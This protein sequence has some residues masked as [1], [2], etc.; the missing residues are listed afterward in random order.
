[1][2]CDAACDAAVEI[3]AVLPAVERETWLLLHLVLEA[4]YRIRLDIR[5]IREDDVIRRLARDGSP[6]IAL[7]QAH[8]LRDTERLD[9]LARDFERGLRHVREIHAHVLPLRRDR[10]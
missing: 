7:E 8:A 6:E 3:E 9:V 10:D 2:R 1:M 5:R 4:V